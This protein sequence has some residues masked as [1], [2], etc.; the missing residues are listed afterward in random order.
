MEVP[1]E[2]VRFTWWNKRDN[3]PIRE[4]LDHALV[5]S[6]WFEEFQRAKVINLPMVGSNHSLILLDTDQRDK[7]S[8]KQFRFESIWV[9]HEECE[10]VISKGWEEDFLRPHC[11]QL[12]QKLNGSRSLLI[13]WSKHTFPNNKKLIGE[14]MADLTK[15]QNE[16]LIE[17]NIQLASQITE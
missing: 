5:N 17:E 2:G 15:V 12:V 6:E 14:L 3:G 16:D 7:V 1:S 9:E 11:Y 8:R 10:E 4:K 13:S